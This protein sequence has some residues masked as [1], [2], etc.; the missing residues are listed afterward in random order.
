VKIPV[1]LRDAPYE[2]TLGDGVRHEV[3]AF[4]TERL[5]QARVAVIIT[6]PE[7]RRQ[8][9]FDF[10][11]DLE[12]HV[13]EVADGEAAKNLTTLAEVCEQLARWGVSR[14]DVVVGVGGGAITDLAG[15]AAAVYLRGVT[16]LHVP[17]SV[18]GQVDAAI[19]GKTAVDIAAGKN[20]VG[21]F[22]QPAGVWCD[23]E[24]LATLNGRERVAGMGEVAKCW[25]LE[26]R[27]SATLARA[28]MSQFIE[29]SVA[30]KAR[31][32][33][34]DEFELTGERALLNY[35]HT[36]GHAIEL[37]ALA[38]DANELRHGEAV[39]IG[40]A[41]AARLARRLGRVGDD[42]VEE[43]D[44]VLDFFGLPSRLTGDFD[45]SQLLEVM[46]RDKKAHHDLT[47][48]LAGENGCEVVTGIDPMV[49]REVLEQFQE[50]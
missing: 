28:T 46:S 16:V 14:H 48:V 50:A 13:L 37:V 10:S 8:P 31:I 33:A 42:V 1:A 23:T 4:I 19:G 2:V 47:F 44:A 30:L 35:G 41:F 5:T 11:F 27:S 39:A 6:S 49:V 29:I 9:W 43:T 45:V 20:L 17:T 25:L 40:L 24:T 22:H 21:A 32:V 38:R 12:T 34:A 18:V 36:L 15:F 26:G 7:I 3:S